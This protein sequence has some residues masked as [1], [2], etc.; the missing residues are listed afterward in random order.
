MKNQGKRLSILSL[1]EA[2]ELYSVPQFSPHEQ[3]YFFTLTDDELAAVNR[4]NSY[5]N[6]IH[7]ILMMGYFRVKRVCLVYGWKDI[8]EDYRY[9]A[10]RYYPKANKQNK[11][12]DRQTRSRLYSTVFNII[13]YQ[14][15]DK[16]VELDVLA[17]LEKRAMLYIDETQLFKDMVALLKSDH[18]A[19]P[20]YSTLQL[21]ISKAIKTEENRLSG[22]ITQFISKPGN[23]LQ[24]IDSNEK[25]CRLKD[26]KKLT[27]TY[28]TGEVR[29]ELERHK[30]LSELSSDALNL[31]SKLK[32]SDGN[33]RYFATRCQQ[34]DINR[35]RE[36][37]KGKTLIYLACFIATRFRIA[38]DSLTQ[39]FLI[40]YKGFDD[41]SI[42]Y[43]DNLVK[44]KALELLADIENIP[45]V[46]D[47]FVDE[48]IDD[49]A[50][51]GAVRGRAFDIIPQS[52]LPLV[53]KKLAKTKSDKAI[54][55]WEFVNNHFGEIVCNIRP[56][57]MALDLGCRDNSVLQKQIDSAKSALTSSSPL[58]HL[59]G[60]LVKKSDKK[61]LGETASDAQE[62]TDKIAN[63]NEMYLYKLL[64]NGLSNGDVYVEN[65]LEFRSFDDYLVSDRVWGK[66][67]KHLSDAG[68]DWMSQPAEDY[69]I[70]LKKMFNEKIEAVS[71]RIEEGNNPYIKRKPNAE[72]LL[73]SKAVTPKDEVLTER[74]FAHFDRQTIVRVLRKVNEET[75]FLDHLRP[76]TN[77][78][79]K[80][81]ASVENLLACIIANGTFQGTHK[82]SD[83]SDQQYKVLKRIEDD[84]LHDEALQKANDS[85]TGAAVR[86]SIFEDFNLDDGQTHSSADGQRYESKYGN[87]LVGH[88]AKYYGRK[89]GAII[90][91]LV[92]SHFAT[93]GKVIPARSHESHHLFDV[94]Y[95]NT[96]D[97]KANII[98]TDTHGTNQF[99]HAILNAFGY[100]F[101][102]RYAGFKRRFLTEFN[103]GCSDGVVIDLAKPINWKLIESE[104]ENITKI[105]LSLGMRAV[106]QSTLVKKLCHYKAHNTTMLAFAEYNRVFKCLHLLDYAN[107]KQLRQVIQESLNRGESLQGLK[108]ALAALGGNQFRG[109][110]P[111]E[112]NMWNS[113]AN[114]LAN[115]IVYYNALI[116]SSF[117]TYCLES[118]NGDQIEHLRSIS[119]ASWENI[120]L[121]GFYDLADNDEHWDIESNMKDLKLMA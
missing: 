60:R 89:K 55:Q 62:Q 98:S 49:S 74:F 69:L 83:I 48:E 80:S 59:D 13:D 24:L 114:L 85:I 67:D 40:A 47:L 79:K 121:N 116:M 96:S 12:L 18:I 104:W 120:T 31:M 95:N 7:L 103:I 92:A 22:M 15:Y 37:D 108:R 42:E 25:H 6:R 61:Y 72:K 84:C 2:K 58:P 110:S 39:S 51:F 43:R 100:Q 29:K 86:L 53:S 17:H 119:P 90:Y 28:K 4:I 105:M 30:I 109:R 113:C 9:V 91:T 115:C 102:P 63:R 41:R 88:A 11:N 66:R 16:S 75:G 111:E 78:H 23:F 73:W 99:N 34:Y 117:K 71:Q 10:E 65:S 45:L 1:P 52:Q 107:D 56:L 68:L 64:F 82:F 19:I 20:R 93:H 38:N 87:P 32:L 36:L 46:L 3:E 26:L 50:L 97:L 5:R 81:T 70:T 21:V 35:L 106:Q 118:G 33:I 14:R 54:F 76:E 8:D 57:L 27:K 112:M 101:T 44:K 77:R 94:V